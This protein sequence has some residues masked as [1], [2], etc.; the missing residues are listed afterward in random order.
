MTSKILG[1]VVHSLLSNNAVRATKYLSRT[2]IVR[3]TRKLVGKKILSRENVEMFLTIGKPNYLER[4]FIK[5]CVKANV[6]FPINKIQIKAYNPPKK[7]LKR[8]K[9]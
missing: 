7:K 1:D 8:K 6:A 5:Q 2:L 4:K 9:S 3:A